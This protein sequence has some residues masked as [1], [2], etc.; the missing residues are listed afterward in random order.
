MNDGQGS[1]MPR[2]CALET[3]ICWASFITLSSQKTLIPCKALRNTHVQGNWWWFLLQVADKVFRGSSL[4]YWTSNNLWLSSSWTQKFEVRDAVH[5]DE[6]WFTE[7]LLGRVQESWSKNEE[8]YKLIEF[9]F[10]SHDGTCPRL[11]SI[12]FLEFVLWKLKFWFS[13]DKNP[14][15]WQA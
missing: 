10:V 9:I 14:N 8:S 5:T 11:N 7:I 12:Q 6:Q 1:E 2:V 13:V 3:Q 4:E 15:P